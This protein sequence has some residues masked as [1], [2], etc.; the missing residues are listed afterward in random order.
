M[1]ILNA[2]KF[3]EAEKPSRLAG[4]SF[5]SARKTSF[6]VDKTKI[7][8]DFPR[9]K[10]S[11]SYCKS[12][13][14]SN[15]Y[16]TS[17]SQFDRTVGGKSGWDSLVCAHQVWDFYGQLFA[18]SL[19]SVAM[20]V[21]INKSQDLDENITFFHPRSFE[22]IVGDFITFLRGD[23]VDSEGQHWMAPCDWEPI[24][25][26]N[27]VCAKFKILPAT[28]GRPEKTHWLMIPISNTNFL[29][30]RFSLSWSHVYRDRLD[31]D[32][33]DL[34]N[35]DISAMEKLC[36]DILNSLEVELSDSALAQQAEAL[37][38]LEDVSLVK[39]YPPLKW[40]IKKEL[41]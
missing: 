7:C 2:I 10:T 36:D 17:R 3:R 15:S 8:L 4:P 37:S 20:T 24:D 22:F 6:T 27:V 21:A 35:H 33:T 25:R 11:Q 31:F 40:G 13:L 30:I 9:H 28:S 14:P 38:G 12:L 34:G 41:A 23:E 1:F 5:R 18:G 19:A 16:D 39:E 26:F 29:S 32:Q